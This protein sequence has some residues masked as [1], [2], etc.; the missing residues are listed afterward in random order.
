MRTSLSPR[1]YSKNPSASVARITAIA[2]CSRKS[3][4]AAAGRE[5][6][7]AAPEVVEHL[8]Q[9]PHQNEHRRD[10]ALGGVLQVD[11][12]QMA[13]PAGRQRPRDVG[14]DPFLEVILGSL[15]ADAEQRMGLDHL[16]PGAPGDQPEGIRIDA[17]GLGER[18]EA[19]LDDGR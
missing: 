9:E 15:G 16:E 1:L 12:V 11:V 5:F 2:P 14:G 19:L 17:L 4:I 6:A 18:F 10:A 8:A 13:V 7:E 3:L